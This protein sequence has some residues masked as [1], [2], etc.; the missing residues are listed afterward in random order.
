MSRVKLV[1][2]AVGIS[3]LIVVGYLY[4]PTGNHGQSG[5]SDYELGVQAAKEA[6]DALSSQGG[7]VKEMSYPQ[8]KAWAVNLSGMKITDDL[9][10]GVKA[11]GNIS[12]LDLSKSNVTD[13]QLA[14]MSKM[15]LMTLVLKLDLSNTA[16]T[17]ACFDNLQ[18]MVVL[19][20]M[21]L[22]GTKCTKAA[23]DKFVRNRD[24]QKTTKL[25]NAKIRLN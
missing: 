9:L 10:G 12:E 25:K 2:I 7:R 23:A 8:G 4:M 14:K 5:P 15:G 1:L 21:N 20:Q 24:A 19:Q 16:V 11:L 22:V 13:E 17:D 6:A 3:L 18:N